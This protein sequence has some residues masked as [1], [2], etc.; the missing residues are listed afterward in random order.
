M[1]VT[2]GMRNNAA[3]ARFVAVRRCRR[4]GDIFLRLADDRVTIPGL[5]LPLASGCWGGCSEVTLSSVAVGATGATAGEL[6]AGA[7][8]LLSASGGDPVTL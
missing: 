8:L 1:A 3:Y 6:G 2:A 7:V 5:V 4:A